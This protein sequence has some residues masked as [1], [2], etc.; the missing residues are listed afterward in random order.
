[1]NAVV[2]PS[3]DAV[4]VRDALE[5]D[6]KTFREAMRH[7]AGG[8][9]V[10]TAGLGDDRTGLT[11]T[12]VSS[13][14]AEPPTLI[15]CVNRSGS[16]W[17]VIQ[18]YGH[19]GVNVLGQEHRPIADR[20]AGRG[21]FKGVERYGVGSWISL[22]TGVSVLED[23]LA[24]FDCE[25]EEAIE[26][27]SHAILIGRVKAARFSEQRNALVYWHGAYADM[28]LDPP[29]DPRAGEAG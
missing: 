22:T 15:V 27:H 12:S 21:G 11:A 2:R 24:A 25:L 16:A 7:L 26:R 8:V 29:T 19:F 13:L 28:I 6:P 10:I 4:D 23:A 14:S 5:T 1:M 18:R 20:F 9:N 3:L 17:P